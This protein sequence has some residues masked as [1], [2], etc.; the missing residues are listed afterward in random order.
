M[1][2]RRGFSLIELLVVF[3]IIGLLMS[4]LLPALQ[5]ARESARRTH[6]KNNLRQMAVAI[7]NYEN[8]HRTLPPGYLHQSGPQGNASGFGWGA[9]LLPYIDQVALYSRMNF[10]VPL[11]DSA[12]L[13]NRELRLPIFVCPS[14]PG[15]P[16]GFV[17]V[18]PIPERYALGCY[19]ACFGPPDLRQNP[20]QPL[21]LF[22]RNSVTRW[23]DVT[24]GISSTLMIGERENG[25]FQRG[26]P[27]GNSFSHETVWSGAVRDWNDHSN[28]Q[29]H[30]V[31]FQTGH[32]PSDPHSDQCDVSVPHLGSAQFMF[33]DGSVRPI[34]VNIDLRIY[35]ALGTRASGEM[36]GDQ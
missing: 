28:D 9:M 26:R 12:N 33:A 34:S 23:Y 4:L 20:E 25:P 13:A 29:A 21:G 10:N 24:D 32:T 36:I 6:C 27:I 5:K 7:Y 17:E 31:L 16:Q 19:V 14:D 11:Y 2:P 8:T 1:N 18:G 30:L 35:T 3:T 22:S 15:L